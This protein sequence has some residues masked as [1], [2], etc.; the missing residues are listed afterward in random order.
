M[1]NRFLFFLSFVVAVS[2]F[3]FSWWFLRDISDNFDYARAEKLILKEKYSQLLEETSAQL[4]R[5][6]K[7]GRIRYYRALAL[8]NLGSYDEALKEADEALSIGYP[9]V[10]ALLLKAEIYGSEKKDTD[11]RLKAAQKAIE[12]DPTY[13]EGFFQRAKAY[14]EKGNLKSAMAD[15][16]TV[17]AQGGDFYYDALLEQTGIFIELKDYHAA[18]SKLS[19]FLA[20]YPDY[21]EA[22]LYLSSIRGAQGRT[23]EAFAALSAAADSGGGIYLYERALALESVGDFRG[24][25]CDLR[26]YMSST[27]KSSAQL[28][29]KAALLAF[30]ADRNKEAL[31]FA[32]S[33]IE[34]AEKKECSYYLLRG[35][36]LFKEGDLK[37]AS[38]D[39]NSARQDREC[40]TIAGKYLAH[41]SYKGVLGYGKYSGK[42]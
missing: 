7:D 24:A 1:S 13:D 33:L 38:D 22:L 10:Q 26:D 17:I 5:H 28:L 9:E 32:R 21:P 30:R 35:R 36:I 6:P 18:E 16:E 40:S 31:A 12:I 4:A 39:F 41:L 37:A 20:K 14:R 2:F 11:S 25:Y 19:M 8:K 27:G 23:K 34:R 29:Y 3:Y 15:L 42:I